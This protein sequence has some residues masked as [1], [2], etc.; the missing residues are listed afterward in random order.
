MKI[1]TAGKAFTDIDAYGGCIAY[2]ELLQKQGFDA[3]AVS[4]APLNE[5]ITKTVRSWDAPIETT[6]TPSDDDTFSLVDVS[7]AKHFEAF[8]DLERIDA[9]IDHH[10]GFEAFW[11]ER[12]G[13]NAHIEAVDAACTQVYELWKEAGLL[14]QMSA[15]S[16]KLLVCGILDNTLNF[17]AAITT[18]RDK[19]AY[20][21]LMKRSGLPDD[22]PATY[23]SECQEQILADLATAAKNDTKTLEFRTFS[24][25]MRVGQI[26]V[27]DAQAV[28][29]N[30]TTLEQAVGGV[31][32]YWF[33][34]I[35]SIADGKSHFYCT[36]GA[37]KVWLAELLDVTFDGDL[38]AASR[39]WLREEILSEDLQTVEL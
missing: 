23:F 39:M 34:N 16:A 32:P 11:Q 25:P 10:P 9:V 15:T 18:D 22:W 31:E 7:E 2:A 37:V 6:Y 35:V 36:S 27:W 21:D 19:T 17:G 13:D 30:K 5:S 12:I 24:V 20:A 14:D 29:D 3:K 38:A 26:V 8:V 28:L 33:V 1:V 4:T